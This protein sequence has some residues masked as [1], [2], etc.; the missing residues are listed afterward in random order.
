MYGWLWRHLPGPTL[1][2]LVWCVLLA[3]LVIYV[4]FEQVFPWIDPWLPFNQIAPEGT[5]TG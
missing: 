4:L 1:A 3:V 2:R 5:E